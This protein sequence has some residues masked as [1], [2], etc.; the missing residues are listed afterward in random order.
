[1]RLGP[2]AG[3]ILPRLR[4]QCVDPLDHVCSSRNDESRAGS[5]DAA[6]F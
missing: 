1:L 2:S 6:S 5:P 3:Q 4:Q